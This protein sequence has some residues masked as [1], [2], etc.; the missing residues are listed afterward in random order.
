MATQNY[1]TTR[2]PSRPTSRPRWTMTTVTRRTPTCTWSEHT[3]ALFILMDTSHSTWLKVSWACHPICSCT[4]AV[5]SKLIHFSFY[6]TL[7]F[8]F[9]FLSFFLIYDSDY[10]SVTNDFRD[11]ANGTF[12]PWTIPPSSQALNPTPWSM[13]SLFG[14]RWRIQTK[15]SVLLW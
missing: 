9:L 7:L 5:L 1:L 3:C 10:D 14:C 11:F 8:S 6:L 12:V 4:C 15:I 13:V 2:T